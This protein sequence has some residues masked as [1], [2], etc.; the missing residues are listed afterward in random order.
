MNLTP[1]KKPRPAC[2]FLLAAQLLYLT[3]AVGQPSIP[4]ENWKENGLPYL[5]NFTPREYGGFIQNWSVIQDNRG[6]IYVANNHGLLEYDGVTWRRYD[7]GGKMKDLRSLAIDSAGTIYVG[8]GKNFGYLVADAREGFRFI[9]LLSRVDKAYHHFNDVWSV[10]ILNNAVYFLTPKYLF[11]WSGNSV[12]VIQS[13]YDFHTAFVVANKLYVRQPVIGL[14]V[15]EGRQ[16]QPVAGGK[17][18]SDKRVYFM[19][20]IE[21]NLLIGTDEHGFFINNGQTTRAFPTSAKKDLL[22]SKLYCGVSLEG[23]YYA[24]GTRRGG[25]LIMNQAGDIVQRIST[26]DGLNDNSVWS[27]HHDHQKGL[28]LALN[29]GI[30]RVEAPAPFTIFNKQNGLEGTVESVHRHNG[31]LYV[32]TSV[33]IQYLDA[34]KVDGITTA[35]FKPVSGIDEY[36]WTFLSDD[37][38]LLTGST[39]GIYTITDSSSRQLTD[40]WQSVFSLIRSRYHPNRIYLGHRNGVGIL[41]KRDGKWQPGGD[42]ANFSEK[43]YQIVEEKP[44]LLWLEVVRDGII[45]VRIQSSQRSSPGDIEV[46]TT[47]F[48]T[49]SGLPP[50]QIKPVLLGGKIRFIASSGIWQ[51]ND[52][53]AQFT[54]DTS[55]LREGRWDFLGVTDEMGS[56][57]L[58]YARDYGRPVQIGFFRTDQHGNYRWQQADF[59]R[60]HDIAYVNHIYPESNGVAWFATSEGLIRYAQRA[61]KKSNQSVRTFIR[62]VTVNEDSIITRGTTRSEFHIFDAGINAIRIE[63]AAPSFDAANETRYQYLLQNFRDQW[64]DW[65]NETWKEFTNLFEGDYQFKVRAKN[66]YGQLS[67]EG[68]FSFRIEPPWFRSWWAYGG[69]F[70]LLLIGVFIIDRIQR[71]RLL[72]K[73]QE[74]LRIT[75]LEAENKRKTEELAEA[76]K[77]Q[78]LLLPKDFLQTDRIEIEAFMRTAT[79]VGGDYYDL[80]PLDRK[81]CQMAFCLGDVSGKGLAAALLMANLQATIRSQSMTSNSAKECIQNANSLLYQTTDPKKFVTMFYGI[82]DTQENTICY[83]NAGHDPPFLFHGDEEPQRLESGGIPLGFIPNYSYTEATAELQPGCRIILYSDGITEAKNAADQEF[84]EKEFQRIL[85]ANRRLSTKSLTEKVLEAVKN[86]SGNTPQSDDITLMVIAIKDGKTT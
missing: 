17:T 45:R 27:L 3:A 10:L 16:L 34:V 83:C 70:L 54:P 11:C 75:L 44:D 48:D 26:A 1:L 24:L 4:A 35:R 67:E 5:R 36:S 6:L 42:F 68:I 43:V 58:S 77:L 56:L 59:L 49:L 73:E 78:Q 72:K 12:Q 31:R 71:S 47:H 28:W 50:D 40:R 55:L 39:L 21:N 86:H 2:L 85:L 22:E 53:T 37:R 32:T 79:E 41:A 9:S 38:H 13:Q 33:G 62:Q 81:C 63:F 18:F 20:Q 64:S 69:Y 65:G 25:L 8:T 80:I 66:I 14:M 82:I 15:L 60:L 29:N 84:G 57:W 61:Q 74:K 76:H 19:T 23:G 7:D 46:E 30:A 52:S 51:F